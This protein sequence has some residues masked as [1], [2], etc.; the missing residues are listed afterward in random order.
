MADEKFNKGP[1]PAKE[2]NKEEKEP[3]KPK[4]AGSGDVKEKDE[5]VEDF[6]SSDI[7]KENSRI[8]QHELRRGYKKLERIDF[9]QT[10]VFI[11]GMEVRKKDDGSY[12]FATEFALNDQVSQFQILVNLYTSS[13][14]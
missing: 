4:E 1:A 13:G 2:A 14:K 5:A 12:E 8:Y 3:E 7:I 10:L 11:S 6:M 9:T